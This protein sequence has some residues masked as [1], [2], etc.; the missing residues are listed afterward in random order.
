MANIR[1][2]KGRIYYHFTFKGVKCTEKAGLAATPENLKTARKVVKLIDAEITNGVFQ[3]EH[4]FPHGTK[5]EIFA[6]RREDPPF[7]RYF[8][9]WLAGK[10]LKET[11]SIG[12]P[13]C[14]DTR[15]R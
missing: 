2:I 5:I 15:A 4:H 8:A 12:W 3:Y 6:P 1:I 7:N 11:T 10:V 14:W 13:A 9:D